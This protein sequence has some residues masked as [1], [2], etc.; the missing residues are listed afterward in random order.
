MFFLF[1]FVRDQVFK[2]PKGAKKVTFLFF[3]KDTNDKSSMY[4]LVANELDDSK[5]Y[6]KWWEFYLPFEMWIFVCLFFF[7]K[8]QVHSGII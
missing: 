6:G 5:S 8:F 3:Y 1:P 7:K 4:K 2:W